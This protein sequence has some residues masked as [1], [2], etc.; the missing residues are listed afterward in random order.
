MAAQPLELLLQA[1][2]LRVQVGHVFLQLRAPLFEIG[3]LAPELQSFDSVPARPGGGGRRR[4]VGAHHFVFIV[5]RTAEISRT[6]VGGATPVERGSLRPALAR[7]I[8]RGRLGGMVLCFRAGT[9]PSASTE[10]KTCST[11]LSQQFARSQIKLKNHQYI[12]GGPT[13]GYIKVTR[14]DPVVV[15]RWR[16]L[17]QMLILQ[18]E[19]FDQGS[20]SLKSAGIDVSADAIRNLERE[21]FDFDALISDDEAKQ[22]AGH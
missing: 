5:P 22:A 20:L 12:G 3:V 14:P 21:I 6:R 13:C 8:W 17:R 9:A 11:D 1:D 19:M 7:G 2:D 18:L 15:Q 10:P 4:S 16:Q